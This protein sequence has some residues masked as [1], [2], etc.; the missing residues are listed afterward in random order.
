MC[1]ESVASVTLSYLFSKKPL[2]SGRDAP[3]NSFVL[4][5]LL[6]V[7]GKKIDEVDYLIANPGFL[8]NVSNKI[9]LI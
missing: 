9:L 6:L 5:F 7:K 3:H 8:Q 2:Y 4:N 1:K